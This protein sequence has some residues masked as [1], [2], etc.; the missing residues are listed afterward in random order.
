MTPSYWA[1]PGYWRLVL[2]EKS[3]IVRP[4]DMLADRRRWFWQRPEPCQ[5]A[6]RARGD[7]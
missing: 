1:S 7:I 6:L 4:F 2:V 5:F 3:Y